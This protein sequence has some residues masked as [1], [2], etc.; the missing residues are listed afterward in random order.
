MI[1]ITYHHPTASMGGEVGEPCAPGKIGFS[2][3][4]SNSDIF[5]HISHRPY[6]VSQQWHV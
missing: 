1:I 3:Y 2:L 4:L 5:G 6:G